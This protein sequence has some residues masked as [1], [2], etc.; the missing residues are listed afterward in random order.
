[1]RRSFLYFFTLYFFQAAAQSFD[2]DQVEQVFR[3]RIKWDNRYIFSSAF[4]DTSGKFSDFYSSTLVTFP[5]KT[6]FDAGFELDLKEK[7]LKDI[8]KNSVK[9]NAS[10]TLGSLRVSYRQTHLGFDSI[11]VKNFY[12]I[13]G[14]FSGLKLDRKFRVVF[15]NV[16]VNFSEENKTFSSAVPRF[17]SVLGWLHLKGIQKNYFYG[18][19][20]VYSDGLPLP[21]PFFGGT[22]PLSGKFLLNVTLPTSFSFQYKNGGTS[23]FM[24][25]SADGFRAGMKYKNSRINLTH[26][27]G[28]VYMAWRQK[29][30]RTATMRLEA[31]YYFYSQVSLSKNAITQSYFPVQPGPYVNLNFTVLFGDNLLERIAEKLK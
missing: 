30:H 17:S 5:L 24:G 22:F 19:A 9:I 29:L 3:P 15:Y 10:Q 26:A 12:S 4:S 13:T 1:M 11:P 16:T 18:I 14:G 27:A 20:F 6:K 23:V 28:Q 31:G 21:V 8:I 7:R 25:A 2:I